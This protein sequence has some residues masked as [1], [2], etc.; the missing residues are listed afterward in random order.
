MPI[1]CQMSR[2]G[3]STQ[4]PHM[5]GQPHYNPVKQ[6]GAQGIPPWGY[7]TRCQPMPQTR[8]PSAGAGLRD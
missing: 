4:N 6:A 8:L 1:S 7:A 3:Q 2:L 5:I